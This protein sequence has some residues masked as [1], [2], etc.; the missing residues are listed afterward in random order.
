MQNLGRNIKFPQGAGG[1]AGRLASTLLVGGAA[2][3]GASQSLFNVEG[4]HRAI[5]FNRLSGIKD[6]VRRMLTACHLYSY[7]LH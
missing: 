6:R 5:V 4:G 3:Y 2:L 7:I 1:G